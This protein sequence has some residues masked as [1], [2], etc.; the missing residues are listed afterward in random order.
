[1]LG[2]RL[3]M[4]RFTRFDLVTTL[5]AVP[6]GLL[7]GLASAAFLIAL[8]WATRTRELHPDLIFT[9]PLIGLAIGLTYHRFGRDTIPGNNLVIDEIHNPRR[10]LP[11]RMAPLIF[12][13]TVLTHLFGGSAGREGTAVQMGASLG[14]QLTHPLRL[15]P[16]RR[17][18]LLIAGASAGFASAIG[19][20]LAGAV[21]GLEMLYVKRYHL[22]AGLESLIA[23]GVAFATTR[24][25]PVPH[26]HYPYYLGAAF[27]PWHLVAVVPAGLACG[28]A[29][30]GFVHLTHAVE[31]VQARVVKRAE[32]RPLL[33][34]L[35]LA[36]L[37]RLEEF[38]RFS[39]LGL[40]VI[41][42]AFDQAARLSDPFFKAG[43]TALT[44]GSGFKGGEFIPLVFIGS[45]LSSAL[46]P[47]LHVPPE[48][49]AGV[50]F[51]AVFGAA[52]NT[53]LACTIMAMELFGPSMGAY[54][55]IG[56]F[57]AYA[58]SGQKGIYK[59]QIGP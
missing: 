53:P 26:T 4:H 17:R 42:E 12:L 50:G 57:S 58:V 41:Q 40:P 23:A 34:G 19:A 47:V 49:L 56:V 36:P 31:W 20:P 25:L 30:R 27:V 37:L 15:V 55:L 29:A 18:R 48:L 8:D 59:S 54:A 5:L 16:E 22:H 1:M 38:R 6:V 44:I 11:F 28:L 35:L 33:A 21:F 52:A 13:S 10:V 43:F 39:G 9:L 45:T 14:D 7:A 3:R 32:F 46:A 2:Y 51:A 24:W